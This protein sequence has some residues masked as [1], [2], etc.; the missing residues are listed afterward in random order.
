[1]T[2]LKP[3]NHTGSVRLETE[4]LILRPTSIT[5]A[6]QMFN[7]WASDPEV[8]RYLKWQPHAD[9]EA[10][11]SVLAGW[12]KDN[13]RLDYYHWG[14]ALKETGQII[15]TCGTFGISEK[16]HSTELGYCMSRVHW[17]KGIMSESVAAVITHLFNTV[18]VN[19]IAACHD[20]NN[21]GSGRVMQKCGMVFEGIK[22]QAGFTARRG[23]FDLA[24][25]A[26]LKSDYNIDA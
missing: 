5:D 19:R 22:R 3:I 2:E 7:N 26:I 13:E 16:N 15:G 6:E 12:D 20:P 18:G 23:F 4:R 21:I 17:G 24:C 10:T 8:T 14:I 25:Y 11:K 1:M 9:I